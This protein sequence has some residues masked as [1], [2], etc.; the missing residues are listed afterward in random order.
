VRFIASQ[1]TRGVRTARPDPSLRKRRSLGM[2]TISGMGQR[3]VPE[4]STKAE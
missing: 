1:G 2:T 4:V 3:F